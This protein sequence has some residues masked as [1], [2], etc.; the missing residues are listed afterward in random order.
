MT[1]YDRVALILLFFI[2]LSIIVDRALANY[3]SRP[4]DDEDLPEAETR[5]DQ[6]LRQAG[7]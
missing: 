6:R 2:G 5:I 7:E 1:A 4:I 3:D